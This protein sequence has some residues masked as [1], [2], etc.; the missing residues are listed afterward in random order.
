VILEALAAGVPVLS[1]AHGAIASTVGDSGKIVP[2]DVTPPA[3][4]E[5]LEQMFA[6]PANLKF[7]GTRARIRYQEKYTLQAC[8]K[9]LFKVFEKISEIQ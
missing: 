1:T 7:M 4:A 8:H 5:A 6:D 2:K 9:R 3:L